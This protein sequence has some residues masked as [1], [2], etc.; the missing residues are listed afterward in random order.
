MS[1]I[2]YLS[3]AGLWCLPPV[4]VKHQIHQPTWKYFTQAANLYFLAVQMNR[5]TSGHPHRA[6]TSIDNCFH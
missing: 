4:A 5:R 1:P 3:V 2:N 6:L